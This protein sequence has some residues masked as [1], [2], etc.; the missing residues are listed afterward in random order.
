[1]KNTIQLHLDAQE[2]ISEYIKETSYHNRTYINTMNKLREDYKGKLYSKLES[3]ADNY[4]FPTID[5]V[6]DQ[7]LG[8][9]K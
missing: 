4:D 5:A 3:Y 9:L 7:Y 6:L 1:M 8:D 2:I